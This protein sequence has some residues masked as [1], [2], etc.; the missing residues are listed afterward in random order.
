MKWVVRH[1][2]IAYRKSRETL[3][4]AVCKFVDAHHSLDHLLVFLTMVGIVRPICYYND[5]NI[6]DL[7]EPSEP[8]LFYLLK[9]FNRPII[10]GHL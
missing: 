7:D 8:T 5:N 6:N 4:W 2:G 9:I 1:I 10:S 3:K